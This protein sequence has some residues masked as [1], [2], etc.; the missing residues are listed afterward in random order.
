MIAK[1]A[2]EKGAFS[3]FGVFNGFFIRQTITLES[4]LVRMGA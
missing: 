4:N 2:D 1:P 3:A